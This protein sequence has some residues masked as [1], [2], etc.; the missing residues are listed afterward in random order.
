[1][2]LPRTKPVALTANQ[3]LHKIQ[4]FLHSK[5][6]MKFLHHQLDIET[7]YN[8]LDRKRRPFFTAVEKLILPN[9]VILFDV[10]GKPNIRHAICMLCS[11]NAVEIFDPNGTSGGEGAD[12]PT[13]IDKLSHIVEELC[14]LS[15]LPTYAYDFNVNPNSVCD[16]WVHWFLYQRIHIGLSQL[17]ISALLDHYDRLDK[18]EL[19]AVACEITDFVKIWPRCPRR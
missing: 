14:S 3:G 16:N 5:H 1:M 15:C 8:S 10:T 9:T 18:D 2:T 7:V 4:E 17:K 12:I 19:T 11:P 6:G 13:W